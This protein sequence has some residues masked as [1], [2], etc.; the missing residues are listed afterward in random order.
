M[1]NKTK[2]GHCM[3]PWPSDWYYPFIHTSLLSP[4]FLQTQKA[5]KK[6]SHHGILSKQN[7]ENQTHKH[8][9]P[10]NVSLSIWT[11]E[12]AAIG[13]FLQS[14]ETPLMGWTQPKTGVSCQGG[15][16][17]PGHFR[18]Q[19]IMIL[20]RALQKSQ[21][22]NSFCPLDK[23]L[24]AERV[25][26]PTPKAFIRAGGIFE[27][28][29]NTGGPRSS[30]F[31]CIQFQRCRRASPFS[32]MLA[33]GSAAPKCPLNICSITKRDVCPM[34]QDDMISLAQ[35]SLGIRTGRIVEGIVFFPQ[36]LQILLLRTAHYMLYS[37]AL[38]S[39]FV[40]QLSACHP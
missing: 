23:M 6:T 7:A 37:K 32:G 13:L 4:K 38:S 18:A 39:E 36:F 31:W 40:W 12:G 8:H 15:L 35:Q 11:T 28:S 10:I 26:F 5:K 3:S 17:A 34:P 9:P 33:V 16:L 24:Q 1:K 22:R 21:P 25:K 2:L 29:S 27:T 19:W 14:A 20:T 30:L